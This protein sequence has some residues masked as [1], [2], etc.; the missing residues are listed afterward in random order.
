MVLAD[1]SLMIYN[2]YHQGGGCMQLTVSKWG[3]SLGLRIPAAVADALSIKNGDRITYE[4]KDDALI[5]KKEISTREIFEAFY[6]K[7]MEQLT[8]DDIGPGSEYDWG[9]D[10][11]GEIF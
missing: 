5:L 3:N 8:A 2:V 11:G 7:T 9:E 10:I 1:N 6:G 4:L